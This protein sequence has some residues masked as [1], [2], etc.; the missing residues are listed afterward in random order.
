MKNPVFKGPYAIQSYDSLRNN[1]NHT[2]LILT[3]FK[4]FNKHTFK[5]KMYFFDGAPL[6]NMMM[7]GGGGGGGDFFF[8]FCPL[9]FLFF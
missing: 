9:F 1:I 3:E 2:K 5:I 7:G 8:F 4:E 6:K